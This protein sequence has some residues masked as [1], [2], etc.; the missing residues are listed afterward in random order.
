MKF[1]KS[2]VKSDAEKGKIVRAIAWC[3]R[4]NMHFQGLYFDEALDGPDGVEIS[5][6]CFEDTPNETIE[7]A[8]SEIKNSRDITCLS[9]L[10]IPKAWG[11]L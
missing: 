1:K 10:T 8:V 3:K 6:F 2:K 11:S 9:L 4:H 7:K 5:L